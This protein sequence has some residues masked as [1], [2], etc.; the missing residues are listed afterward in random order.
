MAA[1]LALL[2]D[3]LQQRV[4][5]D[6]PRARPPQGHLQKRKRDSEPASERG[7]EG[8][9]EGEGKEAGEGPG[10]CR[11]GAPTSPVDSGCR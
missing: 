8:D 10:G 7:R 9:A 4:A 3:L 2:G 5:C 11:R 6:L 1:E